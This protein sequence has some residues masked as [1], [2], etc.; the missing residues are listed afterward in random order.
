MKYYVNKRQWAFSRNVNRGNSKSV[1][2]F[3]P[4]R[5]YAFDVVR[6]YV[7]HDVYYKNAQ[8]SLKRRYTH[9]HTHTHTLSRVKH[10]ERQSGGVSNR[11]AF[12]PNIMTRQTTRLITVNCCFRLSFFLYRVWRDYIPC[13]DQGR[14]LTG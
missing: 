5:I 14:A 10:E 7:I 13:I 2:F 8:A 6:K 4:S 11:V 9:T 1:L 3:P 12:R